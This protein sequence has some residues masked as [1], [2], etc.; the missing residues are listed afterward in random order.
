MKAEIPFGRGTARASRNRT[1]DRRELGVCGN[2]K[3]MEK[4]FV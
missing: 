3:H 2:E 4:S 1:A